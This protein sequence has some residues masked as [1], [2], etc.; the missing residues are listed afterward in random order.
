M[1]NPK[2][3]HRNNLISPVLFPCF[4]VTSDKASTARGLRVECDD[5]SSSGCSVMRQPRGPLRARP[6]S[7]LGS[8]MNSLRFNAAGKCSSA[9][10]AARDRKFR[11]LADTNAMRSEQPCNFAQSV[12]RKLQLAFSTIG[13]PSRRETILSR[14]C[15]SAAVPIKVATSSAAPPRSTTSIPRSG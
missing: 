14:S 10:I 4:D 7:V 3:P 13:L 5:A 9:L 11:G 12:V 8:R 6:G 1:A 15:G 2:F